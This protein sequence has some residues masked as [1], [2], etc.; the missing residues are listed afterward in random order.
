[1]AISFPGYTRPTALGNF[2]LLVTFNEGL[3]DFKYAD[4]ASPSGG[5]L[6]F[7]D[8]S[9]AIE[10]NYEVE[11]W[12]A[13]GNSYIWVQFPSLSSSTNYIYA[14][15]G[16]AS[17]TTPPG[18]TTDGSTW[19]ANYVIV[20]H[21]D[22]TSGTHEDSTANN[23]DGTGTATK[24]ATG[25]I[26]GGDTFNGSTDAITFGTTARPNNNFTFTAWIKTA[27]THQIETEA[28]SGTAGTA[29]QRYAFWAQLVNGDAGAG[30]SVGNNGI[31]VYEHSGAYMPAIAVYIAA[32]GN[33]WNHI[34]V[35]YQAKQ[36]TIYLN[37]VSVHTGLISP[38]PAVYP[39]FAIGS[40]QYG[41]LNGSMDEIRVIQGTR[42]ADWIWA[43]HE[44]QM[45][46]STFVTYEEVVIK[47]T[48]AFI[49][50][51]R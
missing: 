49:L 7:S 1:M 30:L 20:A 27:V 2:P 26:D 29:G 9:G 22:E 31:S 34:A 8:A 43:C 17:E 41:G 5:D 13:S 14:Y 25:V 35:V 6:R 21:L 42:S 10:L 15:W 4:F 51:I 12:N 32:I 11:Q 23:N 44:N 45:V 16:N 19:S 24:N 38:R 33:G 3:T 48:G 36:P 50:F 28:N 40:G 46:G 37:G 18:Y 39:P 47:N